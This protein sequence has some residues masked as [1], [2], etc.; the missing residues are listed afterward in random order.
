MTGYVIA[1]RRCWSCG[2]PMAFN[3]H[4]VPA[5]KGEPICAECMRLA[6]LK[7]VAIGEKPHPIHPDAY[8][9]ISAGDL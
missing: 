2:H 3:P 4:K 1:H 8:P 9:P 6:N 5:L 7:R